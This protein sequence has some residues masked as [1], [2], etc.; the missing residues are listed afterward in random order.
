MFAYELPDDI[1]A[2]RKVD[3][4]WDIAGSKHNFQRV[5]LC[6][7]H[8]DNMAAAVVKRPTTIAL[9]NGRRNLNIFMIIA[10]AAQRANDS[11]C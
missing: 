9:L 7:N 4:L 3:I 2:D 10:W 11:R 6:Y 1:K 5:K 8:A